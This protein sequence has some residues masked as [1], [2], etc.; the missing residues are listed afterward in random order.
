[1]LKCT[2]GPEGKSRGMILKSTNKAIVITVGK[3]IDVPLTKE[4]EKLVLEQFNV[5]G[6][7]IKRIKKKEPVE[8]KQDG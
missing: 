4:E 2:K 5:P 7:E 3:N 8:V 1:M 6:W